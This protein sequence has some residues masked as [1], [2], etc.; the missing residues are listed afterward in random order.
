MA[1][2][3]LLAVPPPSPENLEVMKEEALTEKSKCAPQPCIQGRCPSGSTL[4]RHLD[5]AQELIR[6]Y[7][8]FQ[9][10]GVQRRDGLWKPLY[11]W[12][13]QMNY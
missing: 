1:K 6:K 10:D 7:A 13:D 8:M 3:P 2:Q 9:E 11:R 5:P 4:V 12:L